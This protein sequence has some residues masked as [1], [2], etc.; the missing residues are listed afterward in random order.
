[1]PSLPPNHRLPLL[2][3]VLSLVVG[4]LPLR[5]PAE[6]WRYLSHDSWSTEQG[7]PQDS[8]H[9]I[10]QTSEGYIWAATEAGLARFDGIRFEVFSKSRQAA[11]ASDDICCLLAGTAGGLWIGTGDGLVYLDRNVAVRYGV[12]DGLPATKI[13]ALAWSSGGMLEVSTSA[14]PVRRTESDWLALRGLPHASASAPPAGAVPLAG[15]PEW[16]WTPH[17]V[18]LLRGGAKAT[19]QV[20]REL[21]AGRVTTLAVDR[22]GLAWVGMSTGVVVIDPGAHQSTPLAALRTIPVLS[23]FHDREGNHWIGTESSGLHVLRRRT[24]RSVAPVAEK[25]VTAVA[26]G[27]GSTLWIGTRDDGIYR[28]EGD[29]I[30]GHALTTAAIL[31]LEPALDGG[32]WIGTPDGLKYLDRDDVIRRVSSANGLLDDSIHSLLAAPDGSLWAGTRHGLVHLRGSHSDLLTRASGLGGDMIGS[33]L[34]QGPHTPFLQ[35]THTPESPHVLWVATS[36]GISRLK[37]DGTVTNFA[38]QDGLTTAVVTALSQ[39]SSG[40]LWVVTEDRAVQF[41]DGRQFRPAFTLPP[42]GDRPSPVEGIAFDASNS[43]WIRGE[44]GI[45]RIDSAALAACLYNNPCALP[46]DAVVRYGAADGVRNAEVVPGTTALP[47]FA[48]N[49]EMWF[50][51]RSGVAVADTTAQH[52]SQPGPQVALEHLL[53]DD[54]ALEPAGGE[55]RIPFGH[56]RLTMEFAALTY[57]APA[58]VHYRYRLQGFDSAWQQA[59][60]RRSA[61]YTNLGPGSYSFSVQARQNDG[62]WGPPGAEVRFHVVPPVYR[63]WWFVALLAFAVLAVALQFYLL[64]LRTERA[65]FA[66]VLAERSRIAREIHDTLTQDFVSTCLQLD[67]VSQQLGKGR[68]DQALEQV[69]RARQM[70]TD[71][72]AE[73][74]ESIWQLRAED[75]DGTLP[76]RLARLLQRD[77]FSSLEPTLQVRGAY[78]PLESR[79]EREILR[80]VNEALLNVARHAEAPH[81]RV[82]LLYSDE[83]LALS[84]EDSGMGFDVDQ[85]LQRGGHYGLLGMQERSSVIGGALSIS[86]IRGQGTTI[87]LT[88]PLPPGDGQTL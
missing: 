65:R 48:A 39:E 33:M 14:G 78:R 83:S 35:G 66:A 41:F 45:F 25:A 38:E 85:A 36:G 4:F 68:I 15:S 54:S 18:D 12:P 9:A 40:R 70:V 53:L 22:Q 43:L 46:E 8:V 5:S 27:P 81:A 28:I 72:L 11:F 63:R 57:V 62:A 17:S 58:G 67:I 82:D 51:T 20:G 56:Q 88:I 23:V 59:G 71:G 44:R 69:R 19:W 26:Q 52:G 49:G 64:R 2:G 29:R 32:V 80:L 13:V 24:F 47:T 76:T 6:D 74:R 37:A 1:M 50:P 7:L 31:C 55:L 60:N 77:A 79:V 73:A 30:A 86:S 75:A 21:P 34:L 10:A 61:T 3:L 87:T 84:I 16:T 42:D